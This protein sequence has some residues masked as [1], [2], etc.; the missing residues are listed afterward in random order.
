MNKT[1]IECRIV[2]ELIPIYIEDLTG[3][4]VSEFIEE[5]LEKCEECKDIYIKMKSD[6]YVD[7]TKQETHFNKGILRYVNYIKLWYLICPLSALIFS[8]FGLISILK[9]YEG[10]LMLFSVVC[11]MSDFFYKGTWWDQECI[12]LQEESRDDAKKRWGMFYTR[13]ILLAVPALLVLFVLELHQIF[14]WFSDFFQ[15]II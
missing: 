14:F 4:E 13:P 2:E 10:G 9:I 1:D 6:I 5:H 15:M 8:S 12:N 7:T 11:F 3:K